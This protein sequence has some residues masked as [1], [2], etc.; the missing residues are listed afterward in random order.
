MKREKQ[1][2]KLDIRLPRALVAAAKAK[3]AAEHRPLSQVVRELLRQWV[4]RPAR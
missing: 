2:T 4:T 1:D 3:A